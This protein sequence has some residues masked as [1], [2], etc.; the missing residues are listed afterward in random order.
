MTTRN[1]ADRHWS[2][3]VKGMR[4]MRE[5]RAQHGEDHSCPC[6]DSEAQRGRGRTFSDF[7]DT[8]KR[9]SSPTCCGNPRA[10]DGPTLQELRA[11]KV[12][13]W[14]DDV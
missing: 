9:C 5:D 2:R 13:E 7:A 12:S 6:F 11:P 10:V 4:R 3:R 8:P 1:Y 14:A